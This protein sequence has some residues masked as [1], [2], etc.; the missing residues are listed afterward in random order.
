MARLIAGVSLRD[1]LPHA[2]LLAR[3]GLDPLQLRRQAACA[4]FAV[5]LC[6]R[7]CDRLPP[8]MTAALASWNDRLPESH[9]TMVLRSKQSGAQRLPRP[10][11][12]LLR[13]SPFYLSF[14]LLNTV[15]AERSSFSSSVQTFFL[16]SSS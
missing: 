6:Q 2:I 9:S 13:R 1:R 12:E 3:A 5:S 14:S 11:T 4:M 8:H 16:P 10:L 7:H 15:P